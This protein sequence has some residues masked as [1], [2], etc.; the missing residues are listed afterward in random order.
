MTSISDTEIVNAPGGLVELGYSAVTS[1]ISV[2]TSAVTVVP[3][4]TFVTDG[5]PLLIEFF[6]PYALGPTNSNSTTTVQLFIDG[7]SQLGSWGQYGVTYTVSTFRNPLMLQHRMVLAAGA[8]T[9][10]VRAVSS[11][12]SWGYAAGTGTIAPMFLRV[13]KIIQ[14]SQLLV[15]Q[16]NAPIVT[17]LPSGN[18]VTGQEVDLYVTT[19]YAGYQRYKWDGTAW[20]MIGDSRAGGNWQTWNPTVTQPGNITYGSSYARYIINGKT[21]QVMFY[22]NITGTGT[23]GNAIIIGNLPINIFNVAG[24]YGNYRI[25]D[26]GVT[27]TVGTLVGASQS[28]LSLY[29]DGDGNAVGVGSTSLTNGDILSGWATYECV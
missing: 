17:S 14:A 10:E 16:S 4:M 3:S 6:C 26:A 12:G 24:A 29:R 22:L 1:S 2:S 19:P 23:V 11:T 7:V 27:N 20:Y 5:S 13:S 8:H 15:T 21:V 9:A 25:F 28:S 18:L